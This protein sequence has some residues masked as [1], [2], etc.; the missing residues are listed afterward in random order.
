ML[1]VVTN[2]GVK[3]LVVSAAMMSVAAALTSTAVARADDAL[4]KFQSPSGNIACFLGADNG[5]GVACDIR[6]HTYPIPAMPATCQLDWGDR[7]ELESGGAPALHCHGD[8]L[9]IGG[10]QTLDYGQS[11][12]AG[13]ISCE[14]Q[15][16][17]IECSD[18]TTHHSFF[19]SR[20]RYELN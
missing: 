20:D 16:E 17:G 10:L 12:Q 9:Q 15:P 19:V 3:S 8:T 2:P 7:F 11:L 14:S 13:T 6:H 5:G 18:S 4:Y 1:V